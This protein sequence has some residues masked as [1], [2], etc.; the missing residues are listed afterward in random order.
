MTS[1]AYR[2]RKAL[3]QIE[4]SIFSLVVSCVPVLTIFCLPMLKKTFD[5]LYTTQNLIRAKILILCAG[6]PAY[7]IPKIYD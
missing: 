5:V 3:N 4:K 2:G 1:A 6:G 7:L